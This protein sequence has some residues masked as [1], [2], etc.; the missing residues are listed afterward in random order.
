MFFLVSFMFFSSTKL[1][2]KRSEQVL[3][4]SDVGARVIA[5]MIPVETVLGIGVGG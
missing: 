3:P 5:K 4:R 1:E 2:N